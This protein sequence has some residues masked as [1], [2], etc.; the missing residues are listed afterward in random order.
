MKV[1]GQEAIC[2]Y[3]KIIT[4]ILRLVEHN[5]LVEPCN[6]EQTCHGKNSAW[7][8]PQIPR[9]VLGEPG[10]L[11]EMIG[12]QIKLTVSFL[13]ILIRVVGLFGPK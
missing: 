12:S 3:N 2:I 5:T 6:H 13:L 4:D 8:L 10:F 7:K 11:L 1:T 9:G